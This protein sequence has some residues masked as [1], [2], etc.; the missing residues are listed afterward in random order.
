[1]TVYAVLMIR[2]TLV[3]ESGVYRRIHQLG[4]ACAQTASPHLMVR[5]NDDVEGCGHPMPLRRSNLCAAS[6][7]TRVRRGI[8]YGAQICHTR[9]ALGITTKKKA[10]IALPQTAMKAGRDRGNG[11]EALRQRSQCPLD[12]RRAGIAGSAA[13]VHETGGWARL[14]ADHG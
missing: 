3:T 11:R 10:A 8:T 1:M 6:P 9:P 4:I 7:R 12:S 13:R 2:A 5:P 14:H